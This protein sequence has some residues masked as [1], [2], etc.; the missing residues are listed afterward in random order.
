MES[1]TKSL[2]R[3][4]VSIK[5]GREWQLLRGHPWLFSGGISQVPAKL[6]AADIVDLVDTDGR[7][8][9]CGYYNPACDIAV[10]LLTLD[11]GEQIDSAFVERR[12]QQALELRALAL[13][14]NETN[15]Y[16]LINAEGDFLP[17]IIADR[18]AGTIVL[19]SHT[20]GGDRLLPDVIAAL[21]K[22]MQPS[23]IVVR[24]DAAVRKR[25]GLQLEPPQVVHREG[26]TENPDSVPFFVEV[27]E[28]GLKFKIDPLSGQK[29]G[30]FTDQR[31]KRIAVGKYC[32]HLPPEALLANCFS[33]SGAF[34]IYALASNPGLS[35]INVDQSARA[36]EL[37]RENY[38]INGI[39]ASDHHFVEADAFAWLEEQV[40]Q[41]QKFQFIILD[42]PAFAKSHKDKSPALKAY[43]RLNRLGLKCCVPGALLMT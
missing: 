12:V 35:C 37:A 38:A 36:L 23:M 27:C 14:Q 33:Y 26:G 34:A 22:H 20:A 8:V 10:R 2:A 43:T 28:H 40:S 7:F 17:G 30:F 5:K 15:V 21:V 31:D 19:Q 1:T 29:T 18:F 41:G 3:P 39:A 13:D 9:A 4:K 25:E 11:Q 42:P 6:S 24:N 32:R 16:R